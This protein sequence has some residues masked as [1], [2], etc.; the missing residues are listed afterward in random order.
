MIPRI[1]IGIDDFRSLRELHLDYVDKSGM[2]RELLDR[3][4]VQVSLL[5]RPRRFGKTLNLSMLRAWFEKRDK[6]LSH[7]F[8]D[9]SIWRAGDAYRAHFQRYPVVYLSFKDSKSLTFDECWTAIRLKLEDLFREHAYL[10]HSDRLSEW[11]IRDF[12]A[13]V[14]GGADPGLYARARLNLSAYLHAHHGE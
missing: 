2:I 13:V 9:L 7:L 8:Q 12:R 1:P 14:E 3:A 6:D 11:E 5:P 4:G 10:L